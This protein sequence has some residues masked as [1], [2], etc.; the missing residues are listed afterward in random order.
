MNKSM[1][2][3]E[4]GMMDKLAKEYPAK[5]A[6]ITKVASKVET[7]KLGVM[8]KLAQGIPQ[9]LQYAS[10]NAPQPSLDSLHKAT[11][12]VANSAKLS[13]AILT[14]RDPYG[15]LQKSVASSPIQSTIGLDDF[16]SSRAMPTYRPDGM[17]DRIKLWMNQPGNQK[18]MMYGGGALAGGLG[19]YGLYK[20]LNRPAPRRRPRPGDEYQD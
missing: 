17:M 10:Q 19:L 2:A 13:D 5:T 15:K 12:T 16:G 7:F 11:P 3:F 6:A 8:D 4:Q 1:S 14:R 9:A 18:K 20:M